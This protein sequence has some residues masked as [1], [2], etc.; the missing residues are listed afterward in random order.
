MRDWTKTLM[1]ASCDGVAFWVDSEERSGGRRLA[2]HETAGG[3]ASIIEDMGAATGT[4]NVTAYLCGD[5]AD[6]QAN[7]LIAVMG[8]A[9]PRFLTLPIDGFLMAWPQD[10][11]RSRE[12]DRMGYIAVDL[13]F[14]LESG[15]VGGVL[16]LGSVL[17]AFAGGVG[18][19]AVAFGGLF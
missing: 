13:T 19:A 12:K 16:S 2:V 11:R 6:F 1:A 8:Q 5:L 14:L 15:D 18:L 4:I 10:F 7:A 3:E 17:S 9:G